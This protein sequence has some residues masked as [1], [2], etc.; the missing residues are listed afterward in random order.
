MKQEIVLLLHSCGSQKEEE[1]Y[2]MKCT[3]LGVSFDS[4]YYF[5]TP[6]HQAR[7]LFYYLL[8]IGHYK[9]TKEY[10]IKRSRFDSFLFMYIVKGNGIVRVKNHTYP[11]KEGDFVL[12][13][14][15]HPHEYFAAEQMEILWLHF[16]GAK[17]R[18]FFQAL[19]R[20]YGTVFHCANPE[21]VVSPVHTLLKLFRSS[22]RVSEPTICC[23]IQTLLC[24]LLSDSDSMET[25]FSESSI[26]ET[27]IAY[28]GEHITEKLTVEL[29]AKCVAV[30][31]SHFSRIFK[32]E[33]GTSPYEYITRTRIDLAKK[34]LK[35][36]SFSI[37]EIA[38]NVG[39]TS[40]SNFT[41]VFHTR[42]GISPQ[43]FRNTPF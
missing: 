13:D 7:T 14:C 25:P 36:T 3:E 29:L 20:S 33:T 41:N 11:C 42:V 39:F 19:V 8:C 34:L 4:D 5:H 40:S 2:P 22:Q 21:P 18:D 26:T 12:L 24:N 27:A 31:P 32:K 28:I 38:I 6:S 9:C 30:S 15:Y 35:T 23:L 43:Q 10:H 1:I 16:D 37:G 17:S